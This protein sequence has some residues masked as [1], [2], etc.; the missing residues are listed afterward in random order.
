MEMKPGK[1]SGL[2]RPRSRGELELWAVPEMPGVEEGRRQTLFHRWDPRIKIASLLLFSFCAASVGT[3]GTALLCCAVSASALMVAGTPWRLAA[4]RIAA[5][6]AFLAMF[7]VVLPLTVPVLPGDQVATLGQGIWIQINF[8]GFSVA[9]LVA[10]KAMSVAL[11]MEPL[12]RTGP[13]PRTVNALARLGV[14]DPLCQMLLIMYRY[15]FVFRHEM[16]RLWV[17]MNVRGFRPGTNRR[18]IHIL[19][20]FLGMLFVRSLERT[21]RVHEAMLCR[22][23]TG[24]FP[25]RESFRSTPLDWAL[26]ACWVLGGVAVLLLDRYE[27]LPFSGV[28]R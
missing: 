8:R 22:G 20:N 11:L 17:G 28:F 25:T 12:L 10:A 24:R 1:T 9:A 13:F 27:T 14:P 19:G 4:R 21:E 6:A 15:V 3:V 26:G 2:S 5:M 18:T 16:S 7:F 23:F